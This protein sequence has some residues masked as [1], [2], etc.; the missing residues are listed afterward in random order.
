MIDKDKIISAWSSIIEGLGLDLKDPNF[1][2]TPERIYRSYLEIFD[3][4]NRSSDD[5]LEVHLNKT[6]PS[7]YDQM[8]VASNITAWSF[9][10][11][12]KT[13]IC[14][15]TKTKY[16]RDIKE[17]DE[18]LTFDENFN[19]VTD[20]VTQVFRRQESVLYKITANNEQVH[21]TAEHPFYV[22][23]KGWVKAKD[24][25]LN[26]EV[27]ILKNERGF[28]NSKTRHLVKLTIGP[29]L[30]YFLGAFLSDG[31][32]HRNVIGLEVNELWFA[33]KVKAAIK[34]AFN[35]DCVIEE[36]RRLSGFT[37]KQIIQYRIRII[38]GFLVRL[39][40]QIVGCKKQAR[41]FSLPKVVLN[42]FEIFKA[43][44]QGYTDGDG[45]LLK[46]KEGYYKGI[47]RSSNLKFIQELAEIFNS[48][49]FAKDPD[50][51]NHSIII[52]NFMYDLQQ[53]DKNKNLFLQR[54]ETSIKNKEPITFNLI[55]ESVK[56]TEISQYNCTSNNPFIVYNFETKNTH[57]YLAN[58]FYVHNC[59]HHFLPVKYSISLGY[60]P[61]ET[62]LGL[63]KLARLAITLAKR[64]LLQE[65]LT[66]DIVQCMQEKLQP[67]G[68]IVEVVGAHLCMAMRGIKST[69]S[70]VVTNALTGCFKEH[71]SL[72]H[73]FFQ[74]IKSARTVDI[75]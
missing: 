49:S 19:L 16:I 43:F 64:P 40:N 75:L 54:F 35:L 36:I 73:E 48:K 52:P 21:C 17:N 12:G 59:P 62:V 69:D 47:I 42:E 26:D 29:E 20:V 37:K 30:G 66:S 2:E 8:I 71:S 27:F 22:K 63:S 44:I 3:N 45:T 72:K 10:F 53:I 51:S 39:V 32:V 28:L 1:Q 60:M 13:K 50:D 38:S 6:F 68:C 41:T 5:E 58:N 9:C 33:K 25:N 15:P 4:L 18:I 34:T 61:H 56:I 74:S 65:Q 46:S 70:V 7:S 23:N 11:P 31:Y 55:Y 57:T 24:L 14:T 67:K